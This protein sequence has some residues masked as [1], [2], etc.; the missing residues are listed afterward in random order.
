MKVFEF[1]LN[2]KL[3]PHA[4]YQAF[5]Y[6]PEKNQ[7]KHLGNLC[8]AGELENILPPNKKLLKNLG[9]TIKNAYYLPKHENAETALQN[10]LQQ[11]NSFLAALIKQGNVSWMG[12]LHFVAM[13]I[14]ANSLC[15]SKAGGIKILM[16]RGG[17]V[18]D[19]GAELE[20]QSKAYSP[21]TF[22]SLISGQIAIEDKILA[23][24]PDAL[25]LFETLNL[26]PAIAAM[27]SGKEDKQLR[28]ILKPHQKMLQD[29]SG[30][31]L[32]WHI[33]KI[34]R[35]P[36]PKEHLPVEKGR[37]FKPA[38]T[39]LRY[40]AL[41]AEA[42]HRFRR[43]TSKIAAPKPPSLLK[44]GIPRPKFSFVFLKDPGFKKA[45]LLILALT[46]VLAVGFSFAQIQKKR[47]V[48]LAE[49]QLS[50]ARSKV[51]QAQQ[52]IILNKE[53]EA[54]ELF[55]EALLD[56]KKLQNSPRQKQAEKLITEVTQK[57]TEINKM[58]TVAEP[59]LVFSLREL[60]FNPITIE[61]TGNILYFLNPELGKLYSWNLL[62]GKGQTIE[63]PNAFQLATSV[64][65]ALVFYQKDGNRIFMADGQETKLF[66]P[67]PEFKASLLTSFNNK[68]YLLDNERGQIVKYN[69]FF[70][71]PELAPTSWLAA[72]D[73]RLQN[74]K[75]MAIDGSIWLFGSDSKI[76]R[77]HGGAWQETLNLSIWPEL[78]NPTKIY[79][80]PG[81]PYLYILDPPEN[82]LII[83]DKTGLIIKQYR[84]EKF[85]ALKDFALSGN[86]K[87]IYLLNDKSVYQIST[88]K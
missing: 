72:P 84:S 48:D 8:L 73:R 49:K 1:Y 55:R 37:M 63:L 62:Q 41:P 40:L 19:I 83:L 51:W 79:T 27:P 56:L 9:E 53:K 5:C 14:A 32:I 7:E 33:D 45:I 86:E 87:I 43:K 39:I 82:R 16:A 68:L 70:S 12:N 78:K 46:V 52:D 34:I 13:S 17:E 26:I 58:E 29:Y 15:F 74:A 31:L 35:F 21:Q 25:Q 64:G 66:P 54:N 85:N 10:A 50:D 67:Y 76:H 20:T 28:Q 60:D 71:Q 6:E 42:L 75:S 3:R 69:L 88:E 18:L 4:D 30:L 77:Y 47:A 23:I 24:T 59:E 80:A 36:K 11:A 61:L 22:P 57:L 2:P 81:L 38:G 65:G 44:P